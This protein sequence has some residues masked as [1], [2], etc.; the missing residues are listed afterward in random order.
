MR[1]V[2]LNQSFHPD[3][4]SSAQHLAD[5]AAALTARG[6]QVTVIAARRAYDDPRTLFPRK[7]RWRGVRIVRVGG[8]GLG[9]QAKWRRAVDCLS[10]ILLS[11]LDFAFVPRPDVIVALTSPPLIGVIGLIM[12]LFTE[13]V[14]CIGRW[15]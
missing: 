2:F 15:T 12:A 14:S 6:H 13:P 3:V 1:F 10:F 9:K 8:T 7:E 4:V 5:L 11:C